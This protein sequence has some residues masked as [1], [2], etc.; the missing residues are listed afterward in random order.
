MIR[1]ISQKVRD[2]NRDEFDFSED[3]FGR[4]SPARQDLSRGQRRKGNKLR[5]MSDEE[6]MSTLSRAQQE[7]PEVQ[8]WRN[9]EDPSRVKEKR[10]CCFV[11][12]DLGTKELSMSRSC[13]QKNT[14]HMC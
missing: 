1:K 12:G 14:G 9:E 6:V 13:Y 10:E 2:E 4:S 8:H 7:D 3:L 5:V 11:Y